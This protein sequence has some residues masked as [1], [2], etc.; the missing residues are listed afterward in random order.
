MHLVSAPKE[1]NEVKATV[2]DSVVPKISMDLTSTFVEVNASAKMMIGQNSSVDVANVSNQ[3]QQ[4]ANLSNVTSQPSKTFLPIH[5][6]IHFII[7]F[8][9]IH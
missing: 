7:V 8:F 5:Q 4:V 9:F 1:Q 6:N 2:C 3:P